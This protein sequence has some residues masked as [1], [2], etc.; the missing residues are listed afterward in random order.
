M[1][2]NETSMT[3][4][5]IRPGRRETGLAVLEG[6][7]LVDW[8]ILGF[9]ERRPALLLDQVEKRLRGL[10]L[11]HQPEVVALEQPRKARLWAS[12]LLKAV[13][14]RIQAVAE[15]VEMPLCSY[16][17]VAVRRRLCGARRATRRHLADQVAAR[18]PHLRQHREHGSRWQESYWMPMFAAVAVALV[19]AQDRSL[20]P[21]APRG[22]ECVASG[23]LHRV[24]GRSSP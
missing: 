2:K 18:Y 21:S 23:T 19:C 9:R 24:A 4:L 12:P 1:Q 3:I 6:D 22:A 14:A 17:Q 13:T 7:E 5:A 8:G 15:A 11:R 10:L 16:D 20:S